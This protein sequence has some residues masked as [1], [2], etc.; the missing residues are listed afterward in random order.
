MF[1]I[2]SR[3]HSLQEWMKCLKDICPP[4]D[5]NRKAF[6]DLCRDMYAGGYSVGDA[7]YSLGGQLDVTR[8]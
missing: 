1:T 5:K 6:N 7:V 3:T 4:P 2:S 8:S